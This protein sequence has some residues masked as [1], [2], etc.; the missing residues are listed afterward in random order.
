MVKS[1]NKVQARQVRHIQ[2]IPVDETPNLRERRYSFCFDREQR[3]QKQ[4]RGRGK[5]KNKGKD[6]L[7]HLPISQYL[8][9]PVE[10]TN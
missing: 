4:R 9:G 6:T 2:D 8:A 3:E 5:N 7:I 10:G 1:P